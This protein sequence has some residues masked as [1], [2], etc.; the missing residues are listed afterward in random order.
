MTQADIFN[1]D[2]DHET[3]DADLLFD[4][5]GDE[6]GAETAAGAVFAVMAAVAAAPL[7]PR[8]SVPEYVSHL[9]VKRSVVRWYGSPEEVA[10][11][12]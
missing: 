1:S 2:S 9:R 4:E 11:L 10:A 12:A 5:E 3:I 7:A 6:E 8:Y